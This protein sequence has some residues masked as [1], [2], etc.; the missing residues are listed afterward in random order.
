MKALLLVCLIAPAAAAQVIECP[1]FYPWQDTQVAEV[2]YRHK[3]K[4][5]VAKSKLS[6]AAMYV[7]EAGGTGELQGDTRK[8]KG[9][10]DVHHGFAAGQQKWLVCSYGAG[11][12][13]WWEQLDPRVT[14][15]MLRM[16]DG[17]RDPMDAR[18]ECKAGG[19]AFFRFCP[20]PSC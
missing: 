3:G 5:I 14:S 12:I 7:G 8:V 17:G 6:G 15:C 9:G 4:G 2:P 20:C 18:L 13:T 16:R 11:D 1:K 19:L 10:R